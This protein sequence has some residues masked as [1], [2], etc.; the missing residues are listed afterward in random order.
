MNSQTSQAQTSQVDDLQ[1]VALPS[2]VN[3]AD[4]FIRFT[5]QEW[6]LRAMVDQAT[7]AVSQLVTAAVDGADEQQPGLITVRVRLRGEYLVIEVEDDL[8]AEPPE[9]SPTLAGGNAGIE[10]RNR[11]GKLIW[12]ELPLQG[13]SASA[14]PLPRRDPRRSPASEQ[15]EQ[16]N[17]ISEMDTQVMQRILTGLRRSYEHEA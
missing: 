13:V 9:V 5:L 3:C 16:A 8:D 6:S 11:P 2:A 1:L 7:D 15:G 4:I 14:V 17:P 10:S 12:W